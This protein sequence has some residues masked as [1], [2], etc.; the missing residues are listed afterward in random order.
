MKELIKELVESFGPSGYENE[1]AKTIRGYIQDQVDELY[2]D[3]LGSLIAVKRGRGQGKKVMFS[4][5]ADEIGVVITHIDDQGFL[6]FSNVGGLNPLTLLGNR[7]RFSNGTVGVIGKEKGDPKDLSLDKMYIDIGADSKESATSKVNVGDFA[8]INREFADLG[9]R[10]IAKSMDDRVGCAVL[11]E[12]IRQLQ[13]SPHDLYFVFST[14]EEVGLRGARTSAYGIDPDLGVALDVTLTGDTPEAPRMD[15][16]LGKGAAIKVKDSSM[17]THPKV[18]E[19]MVQ[20]ATD[21]SICY[22]L[23]ILERGG[24]DAGAIHLTRAGV[25]SGTI[26]IPCRY[27]HSASEMVDIDDVKACIDLALAMT[28]ADL[29]AL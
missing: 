25:P 23:E 18:K 14:Q 1:I 3:A 4:A 15:V 2:T 17:I 28:K 21:Q 11:I 29:S 6:R 10:L 16:G 19:L 9:K 20:I 24:T 8:I 5:H 12:V 7:V 22:Q 13:P 27:V 26:S